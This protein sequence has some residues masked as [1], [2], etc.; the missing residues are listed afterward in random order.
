MKRLLLAGVAA[1]ALSACATTYGEIGGWENDGVSADPLTADTFRI[2][3]RGNANTE[4]ATIHDFA[5]LRAAE[6]MRGACFTHFVVV[7]G[8]DQTRVEEVVTPAQETFTVEEKVVDGKVVK[9]RK[10]SYTPESRSLNI[11]PGQD[12]IVR[13]L[14]LSRDAAPPV[15]AHSA[16]EILRFVGPRVVRRKDAPPPL[17][18]DCPPPA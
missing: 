9:V 13:G 11:R 16:E 8:A 6:T 4:A 12:L 15:E 7:D 17:F 14:R 3:S 5:L 1:L 2:R 18:P 10:R